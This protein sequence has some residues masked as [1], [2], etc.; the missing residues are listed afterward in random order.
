M[1][2]V[3]RFDTN[4]KPSGPLLVSKQPNQLGGVL[5][6]IR[7]EEFENTEAILSLSHD[8]ED[9]QGRINSCIP[10]VQPAYVAL[11]SRILGKPTNPRVVTVWNNGDLIGYAPFMETVD[12]IGPLSV[13][14]LKFIGNNIGYPGDILYADIVASEPREQIVRSILSHAKAA[15]KVTKWDLGYLHPLS[16]TYSI[17]QEV[18]KLGDDDVP[19]S[20]SQSYVTLELPSDWGAFIGSLSSNLRQN[21]RR[22]LRRLRERGDLQICL[23]QQPESASRRVSDL[24]RNHARWWKG[25]PK[26]G[27]FGDEAVHRFLTSTA[28]LLASQGR[29]LAFAMELE[30]TP[31]AWN[32]GAFDGRR[33]FEQMLSYDRTYAS[34]SPGMILSILLIRHLLSMNVH[35]VELGP[36][37]DQR[38]RALGGKPTT[39]I[40]IQGYAGWI[41]KIVKVGRAWRR[42]AFS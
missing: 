33:Y 26:E 3:S 36:G 2:S 12:H 28:Q 10:F 23:E 35:R 8:W 27:W 15:W 39:Y 29:Y 24:I 14:T 30:G 16:P 19:F 7:I 25:T 13:P 38:K 11:W 5:E 41:R 21:F 32:M 4:L 31:I 9:F 40:R 6:A 1:V 42:R 22:R 18:L 37:F 20:S 34:Y 17:A